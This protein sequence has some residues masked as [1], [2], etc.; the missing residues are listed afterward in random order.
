MPLPSTG[1]ITV[2]DIAAEFGGDAPHGLTEYYGATGGIPTSGTIK[3]S[4]F[5]GKTGAVECN[6]FSEGGHVG[7]DSWLYS[8]PWKRKS[9]E[10]PDGVTGSVWVNKPDSSRAEVYAQVKHPA[11]SGWF[12]PSST[13]TGY[14][15]IDVNPNTNY[16]WQVI[17]SLTTGAS[18]GLLIADVDT[19]EILNSTYDANTAHVGIDCVANSG[20]RSKLEIQFSVTVGGSSNVTANFSFGHALVRCLS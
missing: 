14:R 12:P 18:R 8:G 13:C 4:D 1:R 17:G 6:I 15:I 19:G 9:V 3:N 5:Y 7:D 20:N 16:L 10:G 2:N 11:Q